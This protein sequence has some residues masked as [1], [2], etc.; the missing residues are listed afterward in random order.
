M[1]VKKRKIIVVSKNDLK[2]LR[3][4]C[5]CSNTLVFHA[6]RFQSDS[7]LSEKVRKLAIEKY[8]GVVATQT[9]VR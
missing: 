8:N 6:L 1:S 5:G 7:E 9:I 4:D 3:E 2:F